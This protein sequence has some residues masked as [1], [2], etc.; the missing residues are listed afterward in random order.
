MTPPTSA[1][2]INIVSSGIATSALA[3]T[4]VLSPQELKQRLQDS[5]RSLLAPSALTGETSVRNIVSALNSYGAQ[6]VDASTRLEVITKFRDNAGNT[7]FQAWASN[8]D[9][10][11]I[12]REWMKAAATGKDGGAWEETIM[13]LL[14]VRNLAV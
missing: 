1:T 11:D 12:F 5:L 7:F 2:P 13:P 14:H 6:E 3:P 4:P 9:A 10:M 8:A